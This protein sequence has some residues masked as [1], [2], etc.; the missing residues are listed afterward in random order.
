MSAQNITVLL[1]HGAF[2]E[3]ASWNPVI[4]RSARSRSPSSR[5]HL[6]AVGAVGGEKE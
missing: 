3:S 2:A 5:W 6:D 4:T 1:L